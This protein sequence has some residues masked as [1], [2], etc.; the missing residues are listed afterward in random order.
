MVFLGLEG[1]NRLPLAFL[2]QPSP[3]DTS[4]TLVNTAKQLNLSLA[5]KTFLCTCERY[6]S[7]QN[8]LSYHSSHATLYI[9]L[10]MGLLTIFGTLITVY[11]V[12]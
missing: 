2:N 3:F 1:V 6:F 4:R 12:L 11:V 5:T 7:G 8:A 9:S 10:Y